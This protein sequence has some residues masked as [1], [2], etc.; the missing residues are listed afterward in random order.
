MLATRHSDNVP[1]TEAKGKPLGRVGIFIVLGFVGLVFATTLIGVQA[2]TSNNTVRI[3]SANN[4]LSATVDLSEAGD[5]NVEWSWFRM[6]NPASTVFDNGDYFA[7]ECERV[8]D[9]PDG[10]NLHARILESGDGSSVALNSESLNQLYC[11]SATSAND[12]EV[13]SVDYGGYVV[14]SSD[15]EEDI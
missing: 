10:S 3:S 6:D 1:G 14:Q 7:E 4:R 12:E 9:A 5:Q 8:G 11:F 15:I 13:Q 2:A